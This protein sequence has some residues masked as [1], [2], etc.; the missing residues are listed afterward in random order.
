MNSTKDSIEFQQAVF[1][2]ESA[3][4]AYMNPDD[5]NYSKARSFIMDM[6]DLDRPFISTSHLIFDLHEWLRDHHGYAHA[7]FFLD[8]IE[9]SVRQGKLTLISGNSE[10]EQEAKNFLQQ[11]PEF[12]FSLREAT[13]AVVM[14]TYQIRRIFTFN[15]SYLRLPTLNQDIRVIPT[16]Y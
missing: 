1:L 6:E 10:L 12:R 3:L 4:M 9:R 5:P 16:A 8:V 7:E 11:C 15:R 14:L 2:D 13:T